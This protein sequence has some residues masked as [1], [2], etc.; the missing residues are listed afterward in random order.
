MLKIFEYNKLSFLTLLVA[1]I[2]NKFE[3]EA[4]GT[5]LW[6]FQGYLLI[7]L[8]VYIIALPTLHFNFANVREELSLEEKELAD[9]PVFWIA[10]TISLIC[11]AVAYLLVR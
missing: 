6:L 9:S 11:Y 10:V 5:L 7:W 1:I 2:V 8:L 3:T 4:S